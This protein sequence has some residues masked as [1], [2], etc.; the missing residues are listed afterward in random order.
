MQKP[1]D[2]LKSLPGAISKGD[3][4]ITAYLRDTMVEGDP[5]VVL[6]PRDVGDLKDIVGLCN[7]DNIPLTVCGS[8]TSM[9]GSAAALSGALVATEKIDKFINI[10][11]DGKIL[12]ATAE[13]GMPLIDFKNHLEEKG[14]FY[15]QHPTSVN[16][17]LLGATVATNATGDDTY[18][19]GPTRRWVRRIKL[20]LTSGEEIQLERPADDQVTEIKSKG[21]Y[22]M[23]GPEIDRF[24]GSE[25]TLGII[26]EVTVDILREVPNYYSLFIPFP[27]NME[28][29][30]FINGIIKSK[31]LTPRS[32]EYADNTGLEVMRTHGTFPK[33]PDDASAIVY[34]NQ[35]YNN[36]ELEAS[37]SIWLNTLEQHSLDQSL[38]DAAIVAVSKKEKEE[39]L[40]WRH[41]I[42]TWINETYRKLETSGGGKVGGDWWVPQPKMLEMMEWFYKI[43]AE[44]GIPHIAY[45]HLG[46]GHPHTNYFTKNSDE[47]KKAKKLVMEASKKAVAYG[48][49]V[50]GEHGIGKVKRYLMPVQYSQKVI[51]EMC[52]L[53][54]HYDPNWILGQGNIF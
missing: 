54:T 52:A 30:T 29:M 47:R 19:Y 15:P 31:T 3:P 14:Y 5:D 36:G 10:T 44:C 21:G 32:L 4:A 23:T 45:A 42:P 2:K 6:R 24:I 48:G 11:D 34:C 39:M 20:L 17:A 51:D 53:K 9:A 16:D 41:Q 35:E 28:A 22:L 7:R 33:L 37:V 8:R 49:G 27:S 13:A 25:G 18:K 12:T 26:T 1:I 46:N 43:S 50:A 38:I 40:S